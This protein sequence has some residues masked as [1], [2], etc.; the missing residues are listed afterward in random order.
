LFS[1]IPVCLEALDLLKI[2]FNV[3]GHLH[4]SKRKKEH[5]TT[6]RHIFISME[7]NKYKPILLESAINKHRKEL[8]K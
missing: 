7:E 1:H 3:H 2:D 5:L 6:D 8:S 4:S